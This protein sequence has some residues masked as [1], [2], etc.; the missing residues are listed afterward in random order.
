MNTGLKKA[1]SGMK[2]KPFLTPVWLTGLALAVVLSLGAWLWCTAD[3]TTIIVIRHAEK[4]AT[5]APDPPLSAAGQARA[6][7][8]VH[9]FG[10][11]GSPGHVSAIFCTP[12]AR[13]RMTI[14]PLAAALGLTPVVLPADDIDALARH[15]LRDGAGGRVLIVGH[16]D[17]VPRIVA[18]LSGK[19]DIPAIGDQEYGTMYIVTVPGIGRANV[20]RM[21]Y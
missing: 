11:A 7:V 8:L 5:G 18:A 4:E 3:S 19:K 21:S 9:M 1:T 17:T 10:N 16:A 12:L 13:S 6:G 15:A 20:L 2:G 14:A